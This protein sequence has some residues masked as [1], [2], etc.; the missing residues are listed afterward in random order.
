MCTLEPEEGTNVVGSFLAAHPEFVPSGAE[1][2]PPGSD[3][4]A[5]TP[6]ARGDVPGGAIVWEGPGTALLFPHRTDTDG[7]FVAA[8]RRVA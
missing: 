7:F 4:R 3:T 8:L 2:W 1:G 5:R 6:D